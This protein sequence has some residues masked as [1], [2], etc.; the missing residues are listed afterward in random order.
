MSFI[1]PF[2]PVWD[3]LNKPRFAKHYTYSGDD[4]GAVIKGDVTV[5]KLWTP[6][7]SRVILNLYKA[8]N[9]CDAYMHVEMKKG[10][11]AVWTAEVSCGHGTYYTYS[12]TNYGKTREVVDMYAK[13]LGVNGQRGMVVDLSLTD[14][15]RFRDSDYV[16]NIKKYNEAVIWEVSVRDFSYALTSSKYPGKYLAFTEEGLVNE[17]GLPVG[18]D[19]LKWLGITHV[20]LLPVLDFFDLESVIDEREE[21]DAYTW[22][23]VT[24]N[25]FSPMGLYSTDPYHGEVRI[26]E[27]KKLIQTLHESSIGVVLD[28]SYNHMERGVPT[29]HKIVPDYY[30]RFWWYGLRSNGT[31]IGNETESRRVMFRKFMFDNIKYWMTEYKVDGFRFDAMALHDMETMQLAERL[32]HGI[33]PDA[34]IYGE[35][36][37]AARSALPKKEKAYLDNIHGI[38]ATRGSAGGITVFDYCLRDGLMGNN[39]KLKE[40]GYA[41]G[42]WDKK[43][44]GM[45]EFGIDGCRRKDYTNWYVNNDMVIHY[46]SCHDDYTVF[47]RLTYGHPEEDMEWVLRTYR[48]AAAAVMLSRGTTFFLGGEEMLRSKDAIRNAVHASAGINSIKWD[49]LRKD[50][51]VYKMACFYRE[52]IKMRRE[53]TFFREGEIKTAVRDDSRIEVKWFTEEGELTACALLN[54]YEESTDFTCPD[55]EWEVLLRDGKVYHGGGDLHEIEKVRGTLQV[56]PQSVMILKF[57]TKGDR[58]L[59]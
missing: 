3:I 20:H 25:Y 55:G 51:D 5:F 15:P 28:V 37:N 26:Y 7:A 59:W 58:P 52:L 54:P 8:G 57:S 1:R 12:V 35:P 53:N 45:T 24:R 31:A 27:L 39:L 4:L 50:S 48:F 42:S 22:G 41:L 6:T 30:F 16:R 29:C 34:L 11:Q 43:F 10:E 49:A 18:L 32:I 13:A 44:L 56:A 38:E 47:D 9:D 19:Y 14:P 40:S 23:Y 2:P 46:I 17:E 21:S 33:N 36:W